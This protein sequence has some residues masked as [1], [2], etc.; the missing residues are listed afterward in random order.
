[1]IEISVLRKR[2]GRT[3]FFLL[4]FFTAL[5]SCTK[6][7]NEVGLGV[8]PPGD[9][10]NLIK[11]DS[12]TI[13]AHTLA[14]DSLPTK[15]LSAVL[16]G[17]YTDPEFGFVQS[18]FYTQIRLGA[19]I[20]NDSLDINFIE[21]DSVILE[22]VY[23]GSSYGSLDP[24]NFRV[25]ELDE[26]LSD[27]ANYYSNYTPQHKG[28]DLIKAGYQT[29]TPEPPQTED[30]TDAPA[31]RLRFPLVESLGVNILSEA[32][33]SV[34]SNNESFLT[35]FKGLYIVPDNNVPPVDHGA[36]FGLDLKH[37]GSKVRVYYR[38]TDPGS[39]DTL[40]LDLLMNEDAV[41]ASEFETDP[42]GFRV[43]SALNDTT[44]G[45]QTIYIQ[46]MGGTKAILRM[47]FFQNYA[48]S[49]MVGINKAELVISINDSLTTAYLPHDRL[50]ITAVNED[51]TDDVFLDD[52]LEG[53]THFGGYLDKPA[54][55]YRFKITRWVQQVLTGEIK[56]NGLYLV[57]TSAAVSANRT[58]LHGYNDGN[59]KMKLEL[60]YT[61]Y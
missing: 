24:Q 8:Q 25:Y 42:T 27:T 20:N 22:L 37:E 30:T 6:P 56:N 50:F 31:P 26:D 44:A 51:G 13:F 4:C 34:L 40:T 46:S 47:P 58:V 10:L 36:I 19:F 16:L 39:E 57:S 33:N 41:W 38:K 11:V 12:T 48:D 18:S 59:K 45:Q 49:G 21:V 35:Y 17:T 54:K 3:A 28:I 1:M 60:F 15:G 53:D 5:G 43:G 7:E 55:E 32:N 14:E 61:K 9:L 29:Q 2:P 52:F 23:D